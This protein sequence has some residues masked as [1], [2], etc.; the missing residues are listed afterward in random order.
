MAVGFNSA[1][2]GLN[3]NVKTY[4]VIG[5]YFDRCNAHNSGQAKTDRLYVMTHS[6]VLLSVYVYCGGLEAVL[7]TML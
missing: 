2:R 6:F 4:A 5:Q 3:K 1:F 7:C